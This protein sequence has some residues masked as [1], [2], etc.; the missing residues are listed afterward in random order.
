M[1]MVVLIGLTPY[2][3]VRTYP[4][5]A[6]FS[7]LRIEQNS[8]HWF[9]PSW[10]RIYPHS[11][12]LVSV[13]V[14][15][16][17]LK[18]LASY[19]VD[20]APYYPEVTQAKLLNAG[21]MPSLWICPPSWNFTIQKFKEYSIPQFELHRAVRTAV[22]TQKRPFFVKYRIRGQEKMFR[23]LGDGTIEGDKSLVK[24]IPFFKDTLYR[25]RSFDP[26]TDL[27]RH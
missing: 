22:E 19:Q 20:L 21:I 4:A 6:M 3:G 10:D 8:N 13:T 26:E 1:W 5:F 23:V 27:C 11:D 18:K 12:D 7:N 15:D 17:D 16:T 2:L 25:F 24:D 14:V 9:M